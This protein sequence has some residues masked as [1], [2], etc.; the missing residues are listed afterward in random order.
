MTYSKDLSTV[1]SQDV[2]R[3]RANE[4]MSRLATK[5]GTEMVSAVDLLQVEYQTHLLSKGKW[6]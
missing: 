6:K 5:N 3:L 4:L 1:F 2:E